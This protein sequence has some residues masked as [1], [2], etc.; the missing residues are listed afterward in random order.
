MIISMYKVICITNRHLCHGDFF[1]K[2]EQL[3]S[4]GADKIILR[5][6]DL[7]EDEYREL[8]KAVMKICRAYSTPCILHSFPDVALKLGVGG[9]HLPLHILRNLS[10]E[11]RTKLIT[12][13]PLLGASCHSADEAREAEALGCNYIIAGHIFETECKHGL[14]GR[15]LEFLKEV[16][17]VVQIPIYAIGGITPENIGKV[18]DAGAKGACVMSGL[19]QAKNVDTYL[20][21]L[22]FGGHK[23][24]IYR[25]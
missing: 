14:Q 24:E 1:K 15:G 3:A 11:K 4:N 18:V 8:A 5:E 6:K 19:M 25:G 9:L 12:E 17:E 23:D 7:S 16:S 20:N 13:L 2:I 22:K 21:L 10:D